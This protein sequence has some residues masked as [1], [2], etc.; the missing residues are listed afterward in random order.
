MDDFG[1]KLVAFFLGIVA[2]M[3]LLLL[4][5]AT[6][7]NMRNKM[8]KEAIERGFAEMVIIDPCRGTTE[9]KWKEPIK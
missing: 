5:G 2:L 9:F 3:V 4:T 7:L 6:P 8:Q 1:E